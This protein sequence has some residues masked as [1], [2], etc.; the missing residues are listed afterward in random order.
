MVFLV[1][2]GVLEVTQFTSIRLI[3]KMEF[4]DDPTNCLNVFDHFVGL[5]LKG[6]SLKICYD[7]DEI[8]NTTKTYEITKCLRQSSFLV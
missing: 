1:I 5:A 4:G 2:S 3:L 6:L 7:T 8:E